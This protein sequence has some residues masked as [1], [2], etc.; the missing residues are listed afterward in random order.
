MSARPD[1]V[2]RLLATPVNDVIDDRAW[3]SGLD[4]IRADIDGAS[5]DV[6]QGDDLLQRSLDL[7][8]DADADVTDNAWNR[9]LGAIRA[10][11]A[12]PPSAGVV[13]ASE[14]FRARR[15]ISRSLAAAAAG[16]GDRQPT[17][18]LDAV[19]GRFVTRYEENHDGHL[20][21]T[22]TG[23]AGFDELVCF[24]WGADH[25]DDVTGNRVVMVTPLAARA[26]ATVAMYDLGSVRHA[27]SFTLEAA[28]P[29]DR[30]DATVKAIRTAFAAAVPYGN[31]LRAWRDYRNRADLTSDLRSLIDSLLEGNTPT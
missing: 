6:A 20:I 13:D 30:D 23:P 8:R 28:S 2:D 16:A 18:Q 22:I 7:L 17:G 31:A 1:P 14:R 24:A 11:A 27:T 25:G 12:A 10:S 26:G 19:D 3:F 4:A 5:A 29:A 21:V 15:T 9:A